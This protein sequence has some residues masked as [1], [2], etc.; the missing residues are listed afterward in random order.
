MYHQRAH[1]GDSPEL[2]EENWENNNFEEALRFCE[3]DPLRPVFERF[4]RP[5]TSMLEGGCG[6][7]HYVAY[8]AD[9]GVRVVG[10]DFA[11]STL[12]RLRGRYRELMLSAGDVGALPFSDDTFDLYYSGGVVEHFETGVEPA[13][14]EARR[15]LRPEGVL[16]ISV[17]YL[18]LLRRVLSPLKSSL[19]KRVPGAEVDAEGARDG[20]QFFQYV[21]TRREFEKILETAGFRVIG[22]QGYGILWGLYDVAFLQ[23][24]GEKLTPGNASGSSTAVSQNEE[25]SQAT[26][27]DSNGRGRTG[28]SLPGFHSQSETQ[29]HSANPSV[30]TSSRSLIKRLIVNEDDGVP[31]VGRSIPF[32]RWACANMMMYVCV[33]KT[34]VNYSSLREL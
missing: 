3:N 9:R 30:Y 1:K 32:M 31:I 16:M 4:A 34:W 18:S 10:L 13:L 15:V 33:K 27:T 22:A 20:R 5:G 24:L 23:K 26:V 6:Q 2:W 8:Y 29:T 28:G 7:G 17:P 25:R 11:Q 21:Y 19:W 14:R 12:A